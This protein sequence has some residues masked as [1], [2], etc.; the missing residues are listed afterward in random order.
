VKV[1][2]SLIALVVLA[3]IAYLVWHFAT[4]RPPQS[5]LLT[6]YYTKMDG[7]SLGTWTISQRGPQPGE[8]PEQYRRYQALYAAVQ[9]VAGPPSDVQAIRFPPGTRVDGV[10]IDGS[11]ANV[12]LSPEVMQ[13]SG[14]FGENG[15]FKALVFTETAVPGIGAVQV[16]VGGRVV[17]TLAHGNF[18]LDAPLRRSDW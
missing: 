14:T 1:A 13:Q 18:E 4:Q 3:G 15:Q 10:T 11:V 12:D 16:T 7:T 5:S 9:E 17:Q 8:T 2:R 6:I